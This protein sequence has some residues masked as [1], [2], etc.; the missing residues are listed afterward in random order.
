LPAFDN[1][2][3]VGRHHGAAVVVDDDRIFY[4]LRGSPR[5]QI[6]YSHAGISLVV[7]RQKLPVIFAAA[8]LAEEIPKPGA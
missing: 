4:D 3:G 6:N 8:E 2:V 7:T 5:A 1:V